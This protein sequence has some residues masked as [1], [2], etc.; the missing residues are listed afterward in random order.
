[1]AGTLVAALPAQLR[2][3]AAACGITAVMTFIRWRGNTRYYVP[4]C[5]VPDTHELVLR[6]GRPA[7]DWLIANH[8]GET[9]I[10]PRAVDM[11]RDQRNCEIWRLKDEGKSA[12]EIGLLYGLHE[13]QVWKIFA[14][15][16][17]AAGRQRATGTRDLF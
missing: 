16:P 6:L 1:M 15:R 13:R 14:E 8:G 12:A 9:M 5:G 7:A 3:M 2:Q 17:R 11:L 10:V 4:R